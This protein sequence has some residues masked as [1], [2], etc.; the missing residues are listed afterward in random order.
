[1]MDEVP[2]L[3]VAA[4]PQA[5]EKVQVLSLDGKWE[6]RMLTFR[7]ESAVG[8]DGGLQGGMSGSPI[9]SMDGKAI[10]VVSTDDWSPLLRS[11]LPAWF[12]RSKKAPVPTRLFPPRRLFQGDPSV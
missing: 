2:P 7:S 4:A 5:G 8:V 12:F 10:A 1:M 3:K 6:S 11:A 9:L